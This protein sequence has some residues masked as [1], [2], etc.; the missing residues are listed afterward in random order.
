MIYSKRMAL[1]F[2]ILVVEGFWAYRGMVES[3]YGT[4]RLVQN[5]IAIFV[6]I[7]VVAC[8]LIV[9]S[10]DGHWCNGAYGFS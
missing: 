5:D 8:R 7:I 3:I 2:S 9:C 4:F 1:T 6:L 10:V